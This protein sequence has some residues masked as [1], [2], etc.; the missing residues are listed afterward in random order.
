MSSPEEVSKLSEAERRQ[1]FGALVRD[2]AQRGSTADPPFEVSEVT[3]TEVVV[4]VAAMMRAA[5][6]TSFEL[7]ALFDV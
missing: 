3:P 4:T 2:Y 1:L 7:A 5:E 6:V